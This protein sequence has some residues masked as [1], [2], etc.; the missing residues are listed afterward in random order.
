MSEEKIEIKEYFECCNKMTNEGFF[1]YKRMSKNT[2]LG[3][4]DAAYN[5][6]PLA[7]SAIRSHFKDYQSEIIRCSEYNKMEF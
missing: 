7:D 3:R 2:E 4:I 5:T 1:Y 6:T